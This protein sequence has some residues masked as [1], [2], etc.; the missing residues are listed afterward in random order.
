M[1]P[2]NI[3]PLSNRPSRVTIGEIQYYSFLRDT[4]CQRVG[5]NLYQIFA[6][7]GQ[8]YWIIVSHVANV[9]I[10]VPVKSSKFIRR[11]SP[12]IQDAYGAT[13]VMRCAQFK[14]STL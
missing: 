12:T 8:K 4:S 11:Q 9:R 13:A 2:L 10:F 14:L 3:K 6:L 5:R 1:P 7:H